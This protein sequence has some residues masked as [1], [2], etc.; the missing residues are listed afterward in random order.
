MR[1]EELRPDYVLYALGTLEDPE[2][3]ELRS[4]LG[5][6][7]KNCAAGVREARALVYSMGAAL[8]G[9]APPRRLRARVLA[10]AGADRP[11]RW[12][13]AAGWAAACAAVLIGAALLDYQDRRFAGD[14]ARVREELGRSSAQTAALR[15]ALDLIQAPET[16]V[17]TFGSGETQP[18]RGRVFVHPTGVVLVASHL[19]APPPG[20]VY[21]M[22]VIRGGRPQPA[23]LF[24]SDR[25][26]NAIHL[27]R[28]SAPVA[29][30]DV[31]AVT[32]EPAN[33]SSA[34][35]SAPLFAAPL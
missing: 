25:Q 30:S 8:D 35:T 3:S 23:G 33:G 2:R 17:V 27:Y 24:Q 1:C 16:R 26:G 5:S 21:E 29:P 31:V 32:V 19:P 10:A 6:G 7:C 28:P 18:P 34:P 13:W 14:L 12:R 4:H 9:P 11:K 20:K 15:E 22:W